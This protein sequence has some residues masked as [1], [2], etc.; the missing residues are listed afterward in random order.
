[1]QNSSLPPATTD[2]FSAIACRY[3][4]ANR[5]LS[6]W[7]DIRWRRLA[8][9]SAPL[10]PGARVLDICTG[11]A[12]TAL[13]FALREPAASITA[14][15]LSKDMLA[16]AAKKIRARGF[17]KNIHLQQADAL[18]LPFSDNSFDI[19]VTSF[20]LRNLKNAGAGLREMK[21]VTK[22]NGH[23][24]I[25]EFFPAT[26]PLVRFYLRR[27]VPWLGAALTGRRNP[28]LY[29]VSSIQRFLTPE[30]CRD[31]IQECGFENI[32]LKPLSSHIAWIFCAKKH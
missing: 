22:K 11:T 4:L 31:L 32:I 13:A 21:R 1:M 26:K 25:L 15:D 17:E 18:R 20:G 28:Y 2:M 3:D 23:I 8:A 16:V 6:L 9:I 5:V 7:Q 30:K 27:I 14:V 10:K 29:L 24:L 19:C 12:D